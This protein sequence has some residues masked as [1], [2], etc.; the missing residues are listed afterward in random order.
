MI[1]LIEM[2]YMTDEIKPQL[3]NVFTTVFTTVTYVIY[4]IEM[5]YM[6]DEIK[7]QLDSTFRAIYT[8]EKERKNLR[9]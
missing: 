9:Y 4:L 7:P 3:D 5:T 2:T 6:T 8:H 1:Y